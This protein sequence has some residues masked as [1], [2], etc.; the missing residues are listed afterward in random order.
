MKFLIGT[1]PYGRDNVGDEAILAA[2]VESIRRAVPDASITVSTDMPEQT[3]LKL[4]VRTVPLFGHKP[5]G[6]SSARLMKEIMDC[7][8]YVWGGATGLSDYPDIAMGIASKVKMMGKKL[9]LFSVG[10]NDELNPWVYT[11]FRGRKRRFLEM[12]GRVS[13]KGRG[14]VD[15]YNRQIQLRTERR[16]KRNLDRADLIIVR[17]EKTREKLEKIGVVQGIHATAD[18]ALILNPADDETLRRIWGRQGL[19]EKGPTIG[20]GLSSQTRVKRLDEMACFLDRVVEKHGCNILFLPMNP[21]TD[22]KL[23]GQI[24]DQMEK[25]PRTKILRGFYEPEEIAAVA[26]KLDLVITSRLHLLIL[27]SLSNRPIMGLSRGSKIDTF[28]GHFGEKS[29]GS[30]RNFKV[31]ELL[32]NCDRLLRSSDEFKAKSENVVKDLRRKAEKNID[33]LREHLSRNEN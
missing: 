28:L 7:D 24:R 16:I 27:A 8:V 31:D 26:S 4:G 13:G 5:P 17:D 9:V 19:F 25:K 33:L 15:L 1:V 10:M 32:E 21:V 12:I 2:T 23:M 18:P 30:V 6:F 3:E 14:F 29:C 11:L 22:S 20:V